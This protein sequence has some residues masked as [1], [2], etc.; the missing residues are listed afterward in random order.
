[1]HTAAHPLSDQTTGTVAPIQ[2][3]DT[4]LSPPDTVQQS[5][6]PE[7]ETTGVPVDGCQ[8]FENSDYNK[9]AEINCEVKRPF[10]CEHPKKDYVPPDQIN[11]LRLG[12]ITQKF[13]KTEKIRN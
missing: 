1:M 7:P 3:I 12:D 10:I 8:W 11:D 9:G 4:T 13:R 5:T 2:T 6:L